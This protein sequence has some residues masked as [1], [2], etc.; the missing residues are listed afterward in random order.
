M[1]LN[2]RTSAAS[3]EMRAVV[4]A[5]ST[6]TGTG[7]DAP[8]LAGLYAA[9]DAGFDWLDVAFKLP[10]FAVLYFELSSLEVVELSPANAIP[11]TLAECKDKG[12]NAAYNDCQRNDGPQGRVPA[13]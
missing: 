9:D 1:Y 13:W 7:A 8:G 5:D 12:P 3:I 4:L 6:S 11:R 10:G 2:E